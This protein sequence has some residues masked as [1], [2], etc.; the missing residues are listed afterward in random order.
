M[1]FGTTQILL[2]A[3]ITVVAALAI[4]FWRLPSPRTVDLLTIGLLA[5]VAVALWRLAANLPQLNEDGL[6][7][8]SAND[9]AAPALVYLVLSGYADLR[10]SP[11]SRRFGQVRALAALA[12]LLVNVGTI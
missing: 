4:A 9:V 10:P 11:D 3:G 1:S 2:T 5:G 12:A 7:G 8:I 6:P